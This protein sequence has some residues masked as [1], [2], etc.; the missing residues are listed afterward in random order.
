MDD[1]TIIYEPGHQD[2]NPET[3]VHGYRLGRQLGR[4]A[5]GTVYLATI[6]GTQETYAIKLIDIR[7]QSDSAINRL[8][9]ECELTSKLNH[10][11]IIKVYEAGYW[12][13]YIF[14]AMEVAQGRSVET[15]TS[16]G[17][18]WRR[19]LDIARRAAAALAHAHDVHGIIH[20]DIKP[21][22]L[23]VDL[24][25]RTI[26]GVKIVDFGLS[27]S[28]DDQL[29]GLTMTGTIL[30]TPF[31]MS[32]EQA[33]G[34]RTL[35]F[36]TDLYALGASVFWMIAGQPPFSKGTSI[37]ILMQH[38]NEPAPNLRSIVRDCPAEVA[39]VVERCLAKN[40]TDRFESYGRFIAE[41]EHLIDDASLQNREHESSGF[42]HRAVTALPGEGVTTPPTQKVT[43]PKPVVSESVSHA[44]LRN[45]AM[46]GFKVAPR[47]PKVHV[48]SLA[49][50]TI[51]DSNFRVTGPIG[52]GAM[53]EVYAV[54]DCVVE[55]HLAMKILSEIDMTR[56]TAVRRFQGE[57]T[58]LAT[59]EHR[60]FPY[61]AGRGTF[62]DRDYLLMERVK[63]IDLKTW[64]ETNGGRMGEAGALQVV[65]QLAH[66]MHR[67]HAKCGMVH[68]DIKPA[69]LMFTYINGEQ[70]VKIVDFGISTYIDYGDF[71]DFS[72]RTYQ[73]IDDDAQGR[74]VGT[75]AYMSP[76]Q[77]RGEPPSPF[78]DI[79]SIGCTFFHLVTGQTPYQAPN[80]AMMMI[81]HM[82]DEPPN[83]DGLTDLSKGTQYLL[84]RCLAK[85]PTDRFQNY[86]QMLDAA[87]SA[88][89]L[90]KTTRIFNPNRII[91]G[92]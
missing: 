52:A 1:D 90:T 67:A 41:L 10:P 45:P 74:A 32:P 88:Y 50:G 57:C 65:Q 61:F 42:R 31:Y 39:T 11:G 35:T 55:Q 36:H 75:P 37:E 40:P 85:N 86:L 64:L 76:E 26:T 34:D 47:P 13:E 16:G 53:G 20:R 71:E 49:P 28:V 7:N 68:R 58:A 22:N 43:R 56:P 24:T 8:V 72:A 89:A 2:S 9:R 48:P 84:K 14:I 66:A 44:V 81:R 27:R 82:Q 46:G 25:G 60:A 30:G 83:L 18:G 54:E 87:K 4:G 5:Q 73:Y 59:V 6:D 3:I 79:Y 63:G 23:V 21:A 33:R 91:D 80:A 51:I 12:G 77:C 19:S 15:F 17:L 92:R 29:G 62:R 69:N 38:C 70:Q 78:M